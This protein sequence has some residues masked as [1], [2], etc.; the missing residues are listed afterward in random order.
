MQKQNQIQTSSH[1][2]TIT[3]TKSSHSPSIASSVQ[4]TSLIRTTSASSSS[5]PSL[6]HRKGEIDGI[7]STSQHP[8]LSTVEKRGNEIPHRP[9]FQASRSEPSL[10]DRGNEH[11]NSLPS[12]KS[13]STQQQPTSPTPSVPKTVNSSTGHRYAVTES[14]ASRNS[15]LINERHFVDEF[16]S[17]QSNESSSNNHSQSDIHPLSFILSSPPSTSQGF[18]F[19][20][21]SA[22][23]H[24]LQVNM[25]ANEMDR[26]NIYT[27][28]NSINSSVNHPLNS[29]RTGNCIPNTQAIQNPSLMQNLANQQTMQA[30]QFFSLHFPHLQQPNQPAQ[31]QH[32]SLQLLRPI[33]SDP[34]SLIPSPFAVPLPLL[35]QAM[36]QQMTNNPIMYGSSMPLSQQSQMS[37]PRMIP[38]F[39]SSNVLPTPFPSYIFP[40]PTNAYM[41]QQQPPHTFSPQ[42]GQMSAQMASS[43]SNGNV[44]NPF[45]MAP[46]YGHETEKGT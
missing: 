38:T 34:T 2:H 7:S 32:P 22:E 21:K 8:S 30:S 26:S 28:S 14:S 35:S 36:S 27:H 11:R 4:T 18:P 19:Q 6:I 31:S 45:P 46:S 42:I 23:R 13:Y 40:I 9:Q 15:P 12:F 10:P 17:T 24:S 25:N 20:E 44:P 43:R 3:R 29:I 16:R 39:A 1:P 37:A 33:S 5:T 41:R